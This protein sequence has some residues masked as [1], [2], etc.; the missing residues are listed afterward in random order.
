MTVNSPIHAGRGVATRLT[1]CLQQARRQGADIVLLPRGEPKVFLER[2]EG[3]DPT[4]DAR[5]VREEKGPDAAE[6]DKVRGPKS[7]EML[8][9]DAR[10]LVVTLIRV[11]QRK[12][13]LRDTTSGRASSLTI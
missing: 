6:R 2:L 12:D 7:S 10:S 5:V 13:I 4:H 11:S 1:S 3:Q 8:A 9:H